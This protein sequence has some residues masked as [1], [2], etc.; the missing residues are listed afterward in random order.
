M[1][2]DVSYCQ[3]VQ[4][5]PPSDVHRRYHDTVYGFPLHDDTELFGRLVLELNQ[6]GLSWSTVLKKEEHFRSAYAGFDIDR[7]AAFGEEERRRLLADPGIIRNRRKVDAAIHNAAC[8]RHIRESHGSFVAWLDA[9][10]G[11]SRSE[12]VALFRETFTFTG[13]E[14]TGEFL[15]STGYLAG[16][17]EPWCPI[18]RRIADLDPPW[19]RIGE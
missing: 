19:R 4:D 12:W 5:L 13:G 1:G 3:T 18:Y 8:V 17:H 2:Q 16:A 7:V 14:I 6:A 10:V 9:H 15:M 11:L